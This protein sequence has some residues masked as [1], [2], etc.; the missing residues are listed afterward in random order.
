MTHELENAIEILRTG[1]YTCVLCADNKIIT[2]ALR[3]VKP[4]MQWLQQGCIPKGFSAADKVVGKA[5]AFLY[6][7]LGATAVY[8]DIMS[9][10]GKMVLEANGIYVQ[11]KTLTDYIQN[12]TKDGMCPFEAVVLECDQPQV[13][14]DAI[15][16]K[17]K[18]LG[19]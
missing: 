18:E 5:T 9:C 14:L 10:S 12:R 4:L 16:R 3:G 13:A 1:E 15:E 6:C 2:T 8:A 19:I 11:Y 7:L 17:M